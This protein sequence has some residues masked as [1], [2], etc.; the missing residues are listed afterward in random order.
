MELAVVVL[1]AG[2]GKRMHSDTPKVL[3]R[4]AG[5]ALLAYVLEAARALRPQ[6]IVVV[7]GHGG[8][9]VRAAFPD[10]GIDWIEQCERLGTGD[11]LKLALPSLA[12]GASVLVPV[13]GL[14]APSA[15]VLPLLNVWAHAGDT[16]TTA[17]RSPIV[18]IAI[19]RIIGI[20]SRTL[21]ER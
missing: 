12:G 1:A 15:P 18:A 7:Y 19:I 8:E 10:A 5:R 3:H 20:S 14:N 21:I 2:Q 9:Q 6:Q 16:P 13:G 17:A 4:L 11:A